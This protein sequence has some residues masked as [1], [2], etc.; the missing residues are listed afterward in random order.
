MGDPT[1]EGIAED[2]AIVETLTNQ[3]AADPE[4]GR[5]ID[6]SDWS[7]ICHIPYEYDGETKACHE[8]GIVLP[9]YKFV[10]FDFDFWELFSRDK[11][12]QCAARYTEFDMV[13]F[14][15]RFMHHQDSTFG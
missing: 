5:R 10:Y 11:C 8:C 9:N 6:T 1:M 7:K 2:A 12:P 14:A 3:D 15:F 4:S 13:E